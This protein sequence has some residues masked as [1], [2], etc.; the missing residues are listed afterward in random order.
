M[1]LLIFMAQANGDE[2]VGR[3]IEERISATFDFG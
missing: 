3:M 1:P 2:Q